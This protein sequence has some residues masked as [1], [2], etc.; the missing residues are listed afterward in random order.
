MEATAYLAGKAAKITCVDMI[1]APFVR[2][3]GEKIGA[4]VQKVCVCGQ[5]YVCVNV[6][7]YVC[8]CMCACSSLVC[9]CMHLYM[10]VQVCVW[11]CVV[12]TIK[13]VNRCLRRRGWSFGS[14]QE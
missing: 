2:V 8:V 13:N 4:M 14:A 5:V 6:Y 12:L 3:L 1:S 10:C 9:V 11:Y 7:A